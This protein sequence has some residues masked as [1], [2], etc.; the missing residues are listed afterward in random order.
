MPGEVRGEVRG[1][2]R[3]EKGFSTTQMFG[4]VLVLSWRLEPEGG[5]LDEGL[6]MPLIIL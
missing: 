5:S 1:D 2:V 3:G 6:G 4:W